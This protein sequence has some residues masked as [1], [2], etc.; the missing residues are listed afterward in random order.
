MRMGI[1]AVTCACGSYLAGMTRFDL[2]PQTRRP[3]A[4]QRS[5][6]APSPS[7]VAILP[8]QPR[9]L[10]ALAPRAGA[11]EVGA[12]CPATSAGST[13]AKRRA[14][15]ADRAPCAREPEMGIAQ[16]PGRAPEATPPAPPT[17]GGG[18]RPEPGRRCAA[19]PRRPARPAP[20]HLD[21]G[22]V[23]P[24]PGPEREHRASCG[25]A[26]PLS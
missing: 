26:A 22:P 9:D 15:G 19:G 20:P 7:G 16:D 8:G 3:C 14:P 18:G 11:M 6:P 10:V 12:L 24:D 5:R 13:R 23:A 21:H 1:Y 4:S 25:P 2:P 17:R